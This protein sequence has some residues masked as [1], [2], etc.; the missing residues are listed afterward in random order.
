[1]KNLEDLKQA[2]FE[3]S[4]QR[5]RP[6]FMTVCAITGGLL[7]IMWGTGTG[8]TV[9]K[10]I[11]APMVGGMVSATILS[12]VVIPV[13]YYLWKSREVKRLVKTTSED[14]QLTN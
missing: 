2:I 13:I 9:M 5:I 3:G 7:P 10:R 4:A 11:A 14:Q 8:A 12:L 1:M 6:I